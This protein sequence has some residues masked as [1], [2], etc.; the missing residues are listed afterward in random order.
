MNLDGLD[1]TEQ[2]IAI[3]GANAALGIY[4]A[5]CLAAELTDLALTPIR[6]T[7]DRLTI[8]ALHLDAVSTLRRAAHRAGV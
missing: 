2:R 5:I 1:E 4:S 3:R 6:A 7:A 8:A